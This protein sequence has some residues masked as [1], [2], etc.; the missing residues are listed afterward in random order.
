MYCYTL[1]I[2]GVPERGI[3][4]SM[5]PGAGLPGVVIGTGEDRVAIP[6]TQ[7]LFDSIVD[8]QQSA[9]QLRECQ[10]KELSLPWMS[11]C[12]VEGGSLDSSGKRKEFV[13]VERAGNE[14]DK[15]ALVHLVPAEDERVRYCGCH[16]IETINEATHKVIRK[17]PKLE[18]IVGIEYLG[19]CHGEHLIIMYPGA[20]FRAQ[21]TGFQKSIRQ[22]YML[23][24]SNS[25]RPRVIDTTKFRRTDRDPK[26]A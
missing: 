22:T 1:V 18:D 17:W 13:L 5:I 15:R 2:G 14:Q 8:V 26:A 10:G 23:S 9:L 25:S 7:A 19:G 21:R 16:Q 20:S 24:S 11:N 3:Q 6:V 4:L 12:D